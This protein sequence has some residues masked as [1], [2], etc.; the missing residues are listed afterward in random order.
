[1][2]WPGKGQGSQHTRNDFAESDFWK[3]IP[4]RG[5][6]KPNE[7]VWKSKIKCANL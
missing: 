6:Y 1:M 3:W 5:A 2:G 4:G 7:E